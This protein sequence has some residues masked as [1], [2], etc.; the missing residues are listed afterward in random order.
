MAI[1]NQRK[2]GSISVRA[3]LPQ[4]SMRR[5]AIHRWGIRRAGVLAKTGFRSRE[6]TKL[7]DHA[8]GR[9]GVA[10]ALSAAYKRSVAATATTAVA[11]TPRSL[12]RDPRSFTDELPA[13]LR[14]IRE[15]NQWA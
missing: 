10:S 7:V 11:P 4:S 2:G 9:L 1:L 14:V 13:P 5:G 8:F 6:V 12:L 15:S 3:H